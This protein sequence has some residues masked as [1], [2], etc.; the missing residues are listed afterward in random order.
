MA[1]RLRDSCRLCGQDA[2]V[3]AHPDLRILDVDCPQCGFL[4]L[5]DDFP[6]VLDSTYSARVRRAVG[7]HLHRDGEAHTQRI[8][9]TK[10]S[11]EK[12]VSRL[13]RDRSLSAS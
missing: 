8:M 12:I 6:Q 10:E 1:M 3:V 4:R 11:F 13:S 9:L 7:E 5:P 2:G